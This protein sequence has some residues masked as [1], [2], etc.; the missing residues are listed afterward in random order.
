[1]LGSIASMPVML[2]PGRATLAIKPAPIGSETSTNDRD[3][4][5]FSLERGD[6]RGCLRDD[7]VWLQSNKFFSKRLKSVRSTLGEAIVH[8]DITAILPSKSFEP[9]CE[10]G[11]PRLHIPIVFFP[12]NQDANARCTGGL[13]RCGRERPC[14]HTAKTA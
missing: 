9:L 10:T 4:I 14:Y 11:Q 2:A 1:M 6:D 13:L 12:C 8:L 5:C 7:Y 3:F